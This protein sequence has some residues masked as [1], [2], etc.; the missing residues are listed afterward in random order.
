MSRKSG[1]QRKPKILI[2]DDDRQIAQGLDLRFRAAGFETSLAHDGGTGLAVAGDWLPDV[3]I[4]DLR[5]PVMDGMNVLAGLAAR[6]TTRHIPVVVLSA[7]VADQAK[8]KSLDLGAR[9]FMEK[10]FDAKQLLSVVGKILADAPGDSAGTK[11]VRRMDA[12]HG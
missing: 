1:A 7:N 6:E 9:C 11:A 12:K 2:V 5:M 10:P 4:L 3:M 8:C